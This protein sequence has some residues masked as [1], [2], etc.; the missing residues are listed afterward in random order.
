MIKVK[1]TKK[2]GGTI[3]DN[4]L[5]QKVISIIDRRREEI[6]SIGSDIYKHPETGFKEFRTSQKVV[7]MFKRLDLKFIEAG[8]IPGVKATIDTGRPGPGLAIMCELDALICREHPDSNKETGAVHA[9]GHNVQVAN[10]LGAAIGLMDSGVLDSLSGKI[11]FIAFPAE[12]YIEIEYRKQLR[13]KGVIHYLGGKPEFLVRGLLDDVHIGALLH[14]MSGNGAK[15]ITY[16][17][18]NGCVVKKIKYIGRASHAGGAPQSG[19][20]A[21][22]AANIGMAAIN[23]LRETFVESDYIRVHPIITKGGDVVNVIP[24]DVRIETFIRGKT[25]EAILD[26]NKK[27][28]RALAGGAISMGAKV[29]IEDL[30]GYYPATYMKE[31]IDITKDVMLGLVK[32]NEI[33]ERNHGTGST[34]LGDLSTIM[35]II[36]PYICGVQGGAH[37]PDFRIVD[38]ETAYILGSKH[39]ALLA[40]HLM[41]NGAQAAKQLIGKYTPYFKSKEEYFDF[42]DKLFALKTYSADD[43]E[44]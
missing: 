16:N 14:T 27:V 17:T 6:I 5:K 31:L 40:V 10:M 42:T 9:C 44:R 22:Y 35:P 20:N 2:K 26:T 23:A 4:I 25:I 1:A 30:P 33:I 34:D 18:S 37:T 36:Q 41:S 29:E 24:S 43:I 13:E 7:E 39:L 32:E 8:N 21:L 38:P 12:E 19:I 11:H 15:I 3:L 28:D